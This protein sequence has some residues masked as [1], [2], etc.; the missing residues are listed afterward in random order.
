MPFGNSTPPPGVETRLFLPRGLQELISGR[1]KMANCVT[2]GSELHPERAEK[3][4]YC[5]RRECQKQNLKGLTILAVGVNKAA[6]QYEVVDGRT[7]AETGERAY[8]GERPA[9]ARAA[10]RPVRA[11]PA[12]RAS[13]S[14]SPRRRWTASQQELAAVYNARGMRPDEIGRKLG[15][16]TRTVIEMILAAKESART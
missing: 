13:G 12:R 1:R 15:V 11:R 4:D 7:R 5:T 3:Y 8:A 9:P 16:G 14:E 2:C 6:D 10:K